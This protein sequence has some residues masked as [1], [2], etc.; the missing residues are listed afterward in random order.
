MYD[1]ATLADIQ[2]R[3]EKRWVIRP[4]EIETLLKMAIE[5]LRWKEGANAKVPA[6]ADAQVDAANA[7][8]LADMY[9]DYQKKAFGP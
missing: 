7:K 9:R 5:M 3:L 1:H 8:K 6:T 4:D 2:K